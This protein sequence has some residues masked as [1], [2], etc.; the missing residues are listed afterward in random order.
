MNKYKLTYLVLISVLSAEFA[1]LHAQESEVFE[2]EDYEVVGKY[3]QTDQINILSHM[4]QVQPLDDIV[5]R[6]KETHYA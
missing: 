1:N 4:D 2:L 5:P 3:L 6:T